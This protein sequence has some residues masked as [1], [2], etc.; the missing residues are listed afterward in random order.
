MRPAQR[1]ALVYTQ[2]DDALGDYAQ[3]AHIDPDAELISPTLPIR[4]PMATFF[5]GAPD[6]TL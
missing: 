2:P 4:A 5:A 1:D 6:T 3:S